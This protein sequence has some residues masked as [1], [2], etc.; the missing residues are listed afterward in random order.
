M[1]P[2]NLTPYVGESELDREPFAEWYPR[3]RS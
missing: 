2:K 1:W 3:V